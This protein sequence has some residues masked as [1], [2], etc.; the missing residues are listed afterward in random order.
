[1]LI[2]R[3]GRWRRRW[4]NLKPRNSGPEGRRFRVGAHFLDFDFEYCRGVMDNVAL[5]NEGRA[6]VRD[7]SPAVLQRAITLARFRTDDELEIDYAPATSPNAEGG[8]W[9]AAWIYVGPEELFPPD[10][11]DAAPLVLVTTDAV[12][13]DAS[14]SE[15]DFDLVLAAARDVLEHWNSG[16]LAGAVR[17]FA[18][19]V[20]EVEATRSFEASAVEAFA[21][22]S[23]AHG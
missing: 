14:G 22:S 16:D 5:L 21:L 15:A 9:V 12:G 2:K 4:P 23:A 1:M 6:C 7:L 17:H 18:M 10:E 20:D 3:F 8:V 19:V 11:E 13:C